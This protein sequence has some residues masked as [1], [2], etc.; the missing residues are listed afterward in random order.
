M[1]LNHRELFYHIYY[2]SLLLLAAALPLSMYM[3]SL[4]QL[5]MLS[6]W[7]LGGNVINKFK[8][9]FTNKAVLVLTSVYLLHLLGLLWTSD[10]D[11]ALK[12]LRIKLPLLALPVIFSSSKPLSPKLVDW[13]LYIFISAVVISTLISFY[14][15]LGYSKKE[16]YDIRDISIFISHIRLALLVC[17]AVFGCVYF[18][19]I[20]KSFKWLLLPVVTWLVFFLFLLESVTGIGILLICLLAFLIYSIIKSGRL[21]YKVVFITAF[22]TVTLFV[23]KEVNSAWREVTEINKPDKSSLEKLTAGGNPYQHHYERNEMENG[24]PVY[25]YICEDELEQEWNK[26]SKIGYGLRDNKGNEIRYGLW[27]FLSSKGL[28]KDSAGISK[29]NDDEIA[30]IENGIPNIILMK[31][32][33]FKSRLYIVCWEINNYIQGRNPNGHSVTMRLEFWK[34]AFYIIKHHPVIGVG[35]GDLPQAY[36]RAYILIQSPLNP[37]WR[38]RA[39][40]QF[41]SIAAALGIPALIF[42]LYSLFAPYF[43]LKKQTVF[44]CMVFLITAF[45]S[46]L[47][48][49]TLETQAGV[50]FFAFFNSFFLFLFKED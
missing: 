21:L 38:L 20:N 17:L 27:R 33:S 6:A 11:D 10:F 49:D 43:I 29:L 4:S 35:T 23:L 8:S 42:F 9:A 39:H 2:A 1:K 44:L 30:A 36:K 45:M 15:F 12:D 28:R 32:G 26:R 13:I 46:M 40:N 5:I 22:V 3:M 18:F 41:L 37:E 34:T 14:V 24:N 16:V 47:S 19:R 25:I 31:R 48:E 7:F 50:T